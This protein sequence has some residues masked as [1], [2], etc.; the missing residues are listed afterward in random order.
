MSH[1]KPLWEDMEDIVKHFYEDERRHYEDC[2]EC[3]DNVEH[4]IFLTL[5]RVAQK[6]NFNMEERC[7]GHR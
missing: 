7:H 1:T 3:G 4:H 6:C 2:L 5:Q